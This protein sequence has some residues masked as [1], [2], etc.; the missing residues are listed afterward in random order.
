MRTYEALRQRHMADAMALAPQLIERLDWSSDR[1][2]AHRQQ[3]LRE[4]VVHAVTRSPWHRERLAGVDVAHLDESSLPDLPPMTKRDLMDNYDRIVTDPRVTL[5]RV[6]AYLQT[7]EENGYLLDRY[8]AI[9]SGGSSG[10]RG[11]FVYDWEGWALFWLGCLRHLLRAKQAD[12]E[13]A[14]RPLKIAWVMAGHFTHATAALGR[15]FANPNVIN[16]RFPVTLPIEEIVAGLNDVQPDFVNAYPSALH[17]LSFEAQAGRLRI[18]PR[19]VQS[20]AEPLLPEIRAAAEA[21]WGVRVGN[22]Y[23]TSEAGGTG[24]PCDERRTHLSEDLV[25]VESVDAQGGPVAPGVPA[26]KIYLTNLYNR[27]MPLIRYEITDEVTVLREPCP[28]GSA[29]RCVADIQGRLEDTF[30]Y[31]QR[32]VH[33]LVF[34]TALGRRAPIVEYQV[35]QTPTGAHI[36]VRCQSRVDLDE[37]ARE[38]EDGLARL[39]L[40]QPGVTV[41]A[42]AQLQRTDGPAKLTRFVALPASRPERAYVSAGSSAATSL[43]FG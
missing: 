13:L 7:V 25:I 38:I 10:E 34:H 22:L 19:R 17:L 33:P 14:A 31:G 36:A 30:F 29:H 27:A 4:I 26:A 18:Q 1:L 2:A 6:N 35:R 20:A 32:P 5:A 3:Q 8:T 21:A 12:P 24:T 28:C 43:P 41:E 15:T 23:G 40:E 11:V 9:T 42:V 39:G 16:H 37:L